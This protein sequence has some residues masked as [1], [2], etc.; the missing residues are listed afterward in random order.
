MTSLIDEISGGG[1]SRK[2][3]KMSDYEWL[4]FDPPNNE[5]SK[6]SLIWKTQ[7][8]FMMSDFLWSCKS[9]SFTDFYEWLLSFCHSEKVS[10][11]SSLHFDQKAW[12]Y[13]HRFWWYWVTFW[14][15]EKVTH[16]DSYILIKP[17][18]Y[19]ITVFYNTEWLFENLKNHSFT[20]SWCRGKMSDFSSVS[21]VA[22]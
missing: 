11:L 10:H 4:L 16:L 21:K 6:K 7:K 5:I 2:I 8:A 20:V 13:T 22:H 19:L 3:S 12:V 14:D 17:R 9:H 1:G 18:E 15:S